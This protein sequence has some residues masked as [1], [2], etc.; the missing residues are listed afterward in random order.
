MDDVALKVLTIDQFDDLVTQVGSYLAT[1]VDVRL[2]KKVIIGGVVLFAGGFYLGA[3]NYRRYLTE[4][5]TI[6]PKIQDEANKEAP[7]SFQ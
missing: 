4:H 6:T 1:Q 5:F 3:K 2:G 7:K